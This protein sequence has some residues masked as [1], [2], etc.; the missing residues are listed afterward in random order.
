MKPRIFKITRDGLTIAYG[1]MFSNNGK[2]VVSSKGNGSV[3][4]I[5][6]TYDDMLHAYPEEHTKII[7]Y[8]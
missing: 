2:C 4:L 7:F 5:W 1:C 8:D 3:T 6:D